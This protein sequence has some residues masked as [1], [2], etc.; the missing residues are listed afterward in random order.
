LTSDEDAAYLSKDVQG[1]ML[2]NH[3]NHITT[4]ENNHHILGIVNRFIKNLRDLNQDRDISDDNMNSIVEEY[5]SRQH[6]SIGKAP[7]NFGESNEISWMNKK[8]RETRRKTRTGLPVG[9]MVK[10]LNEGSFTKKRMNYSRDAYKINSRDGN[11]YIVEAKDKS[12]GRYPGYKLHET[13]SNAPIAKTLNDDRYGIVDKILSFNP[14]RNKYKLVNEGGVRDEVGPKI[15]RKGNPTL[16]SI[17][18]A[19]Y[20]NAMGGKNKLPEGMQKL[21]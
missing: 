7:D 21:V 10:L 16:L 15:L 20:W 13:G 17:A 9:S 5:N 3:I 2:R 4:E 6:S 19:A 8:M 11:Q 1:F 14:K 12:V 18:E